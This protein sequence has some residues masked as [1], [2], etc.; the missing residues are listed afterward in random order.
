M[1]TLFYAGALTLIALFLSFK[2]VQQRLGTG[3]LLGTG[4]SFELLQANRAHGNLVENAVF[5][6]ILTGLMEVSGQFSN[7]TIGILGDIFILARISHAYGIF[8][9]ESSSMF[10]TVGA[11]TSMVVL[12]IQAWLALW[13]S[14]AWLAANNWGF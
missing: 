1:L 13:V 12:L 10:R 4:E 14:G 8:Q 9:A 5:F 6:L 2:T 7:L 11:V 3:I